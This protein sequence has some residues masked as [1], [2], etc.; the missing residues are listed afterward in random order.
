MELKGIIIPFA[1]TKARATRLYIENLEKQLAD[2]DNPILNHICS[3][4]DLAL[5]Q[6]ALKKL[7]KELQYCFSWK[8]YRFHAV[9]SFC[10]FT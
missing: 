9:M 1:K 10:D 5:K 3:L 8:Q 6:S 4:M 7:N 2:L